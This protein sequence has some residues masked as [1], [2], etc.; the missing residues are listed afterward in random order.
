MTEAMAHLQAA[1]FKLEQRLQLW[2]IE[3]ED[4]EAIAVQAALDLVETAV[5]WLKG[6][7]R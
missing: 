1:A 5:Y 4:P 7:D 3:D 6:L 2:S